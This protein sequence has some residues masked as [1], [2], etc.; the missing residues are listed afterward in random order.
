VH[1]KYTENEIIEGAMYPSTAHVKDAVKQWS[2][3]TLHREFR[4][5]KSS[6]RIYD[7]HCKEEDCAFRV[8]C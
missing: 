1:W 6:S 7:V 3:L 8:Y 5:V 2:T 4:I